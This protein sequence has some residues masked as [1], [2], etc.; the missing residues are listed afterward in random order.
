LFVYYL[1]NKLIF[2]LLHEKKFFSMWE[3][4][5]KVKSRVVNARDE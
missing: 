1:Y 5:I 3:M 2:V 4:G